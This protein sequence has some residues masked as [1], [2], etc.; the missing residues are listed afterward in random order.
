MERANQHPALQ[1]SM[2]DPSLM[3][4]HVTNCAD[5][6]ACNAA[7][8][9]GSSINDLYVYAVRTMSGDAFPARLNCQISIHG[10]NILSK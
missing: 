4:W 7:M 3:P 5:F 8:L 6:N 9:N 1:D 2:P 10:A